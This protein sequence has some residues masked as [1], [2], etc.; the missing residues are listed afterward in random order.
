MPQLK[1]DAAKCI[2]NL[3]EYWF[4]WQSNCLLR[5]LPDSLGLI[6]LLE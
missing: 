2:R 4:E 3:F 6:I 1:I 5:V